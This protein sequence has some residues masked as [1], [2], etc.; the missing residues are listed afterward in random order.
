[1]E[2]SSGTPSPARIRPPPQPKR[3]VVEKWSLFEALTK[4]LH[5][6]NQFHTS[7]YRPG[8]QSGAELWQL[9]AELHGP[10]GELNVLGEDL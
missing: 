1:M 5:Q 2:I 3:K 6:A 4:K 7:P 10:N 9:D 8:M